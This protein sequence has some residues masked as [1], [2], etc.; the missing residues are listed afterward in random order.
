MRVASILIGAKLMLTR[1]ATFLGCFFTLLLVL[2][3]GGGYAGEATPEA[4]ETRPTA[5]PAAAPQ[6]ALATF[7]IPDDPAWDL[8]LK[9]DF[10]GAVAA[11]NAAL[12]KT[13]GELPLLEGLR[14]AQVALG[15]Y[16]GSQQ[17]T[18]KMIAACA[19]AGLAR[20][21]ARRAMDGL[22]YTEGRQAVLDAFRK[23]AE[24]APPPVA[25][26]WKEHLA[27]C[28]FSADKPQEARQALADCGFISQ[29]QFLAGPFGSKDKNDPFDRR[30]APERP[31]KSLDFSDDNGRPVETLQNAETAVT[32]LPIGSLMHGG[33]GVYHAF[34]NLRSD[35][36]QN[37]LLRV[38]GSQPCRMYLR[39]MPVLQQPSEEQFQRE[40]ETIEA[41]LTQGNNPVLV[42]MLSPVFLTV[43]VLAPDFGPAKGVKV[44]PL[45]PDEL[46]RHETSPVRGLLFSKKAPGPTARYF[47]N[48][49]TGEQRAKGLKGIAQSGGLPLS[50]AGWLDHASEN[51]NDPRARLAIAQA[52]R[53]TAPESAGVLDLAAHILEQAGEN[54]GN[55]A[56]REVEESRRL[57]EQALQKTPDSHQHLL[58]LYFFFQERKLPDQAYEKIKACVA[59][60]PNSP[61]ATSELAKMNMQKGYLVEAE[62]GYEK[63][64]RLDPVFLGALAR[65]H[66]SSGSHVR[67]RELFAKQVEL[68]MINLQSQFENALFADKHAEAERLLAQLERL[69]P[70]RGEVLALHRVR[71]LTA[72]GDIPAACAL[73]KAQYEKLPKEFRSKAQLNDL[74]DLTL[75]LEK[76]EEARRHLREFFAQHPDE[77][78]V[79]DRLEALEGGTAARWWEPYDINV[80]DIDTA[81]FTKE[82]YRNANHAWIVDFMV[83][84]VLPDLST[85]SY[86]HIAQKV[87][88]QSGVGELSEV[89]VQAQ[90]NNIVF[91]RTLNPDGSAFEPQNVHNFNL[92][93]S[94]SL[95]KVV[96]GSI[97]EHAYVQQNPMGP[98]EDALHLAFNFNAIDA[99]RA[100]SRWVLLVADEAKS[101]LNINKVRPEMVE[102]KILPGPPG[103]TVWQWTNKQVEG[104]KREP[105]MPRE[106]DRESIPLV[107]VESVE[108][109]YPASRWLIREER[110]F[111][112]PEA[113]E[114]A[115]KIIAGLGDKASETAKFNAIID[116]VRLNI[117]QNNEQKTLDDVWFSRSGNARQMTLLAREMAQGQ[118]LKVRSALVN[119]SYLPGRVFHSN[120][121]KRQWDPGQLGFFGNGGHMLVLEPSY[122]TEHWAQFAASGAKYHNPYELNPAQ[123]GALALSVDED[124]ARIKR[125]CGD[126]L[127]LTARSSQIKVAFDKQGTGLL[128]GIIQLNSSLSGQVRELLSDPRRRQPIKDSILQPWPGIE[129]AQVAFQGE[130]NISG[131]LGFVFGGKIKRQAASD[132]KFVMAPF[133]NP[134]NLLV[135]RGPAERENDLLVKFGVERGSPAAA[136]GEIADLDQS[137]TYVAPEGHGWTQVPDDLFI[138]TEFGFYLADFNVRGRTLTCTRSHLMPMQRVTPE[139]YP[140]LQEFLSRI[141][142]HAEQRVAFAPLNAES[143]GPEV[144]EVCST[145]YSS[146]GDK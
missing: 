32:R 123:P 50:E 1:R 79:R 63:A 5:A 84:R 91:I 92:Q 111:L 48:R 105:F 30:H 3:C 29:W 67:G 57:R 70:Q 107:Q 131:P 45:P 6:K 61:F 44:L 51:E 15:D 71:L 18:L 75:R 78:D 113:H 22:N 80:R 120:T 118:G 2:L 88:N 52:L 16:A 64:A 65:F 144:Q 69:Y 82:K 127:G 33:N 108:P 90:R 28:F 46:A 124:G 109:V 117:Q 126:Q 9:N 99:P 115:A 134:P 37:V 41:H 85:E 72:K 13:P 114:E 87:L 11:F 128:T 122:G 68:G 81:A 96:P 136:T 74:V 106:F 101:K 39:G 141:A 102:E 146:S 89:L 145:G 94:A 140:R 125:V 100:V 36:D 53:A 76:T 77:L 54:M 110:A 10:P 17:T 143:F 26:V 55:S 42:K 95:Y 14:S 137:I 25:V 138:V 34:T 58:G 116:W 98:D 7:K 142:S 66:N 133:P 43:Q 129:G 104:I 31:L 8:Y 38:S 97:L 93:Q 130:N 20:V 4:P 21:I 19:D 60:H 86:V 121:A 35:I 23:A 132:G 112:P 73:L 56:A 12:E 83:T 24:T 103:F 135:L 27:W 49:L 59:A 119:G 40:T 47:L 139:K 62:Q